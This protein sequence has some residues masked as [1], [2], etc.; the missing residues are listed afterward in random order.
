MKKFKTKLENKVN[1]NWKFAIKNASLIVASPII[2]I[3]ICIILLIPI[4]IVFSIIGFT[5]FWIVT[6]GF[7]YLIGLFVFT[8]MLFKVILNFIDYYKEENTDF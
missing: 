2:T 7:Y 5:E 1:N 8:L 6:R 3:A 4:A